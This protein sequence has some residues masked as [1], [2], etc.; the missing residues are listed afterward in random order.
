M[1]IK[2]TILGLNR[3]GASIGL[4][5]A[6]RKE[7]LQLLRVGNDRE[8]GFARQAEK[9][10][11]IDKVVIN[12]HN[13]VEDADI[14]I[15]AL[16]VNEIRSTLEVI[17]SD[18]KPGVVVVDTSPVKSSVMSWAAELLPE[19]RFF[20]SITPSLSATA[21]LDGDNSVEK[22]HAD[23]FKDS[24]MLITSPHGTDESALNLANNLTSLLGAKPLYSD[25]AESDGLLA[26]THLLPGIVSAALVNATTGQPG[27]REARKVAS[28][29][30][31]QATELALQRDDP[32]NPGQT[33]LLNPENTARMIDAM[34]DELA[35]IR[36]GLRSGETEQVQACLKQA[37]DARALW[38]AQRQ[39]GD[40]EPRADKDVKMPSGSEII[41]RLFGI[42]PRKD[43]K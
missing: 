33:A 31:A 36:D 25:A 20:I 39:K 16:P 26:A 21:L 32:S 19:D 40:W 10:G 11:A 23:L 37:Q 34:I 5:L 24:L 15:L 22:A 1:T 6:S 41:G 42:R 38:W 7:Q 2:L 29:A 9:M 27:W 28:R 3:I 17:A 14:V 43:K 13:A 8:H 30:Y 4:S 35:K 12:L 18:L